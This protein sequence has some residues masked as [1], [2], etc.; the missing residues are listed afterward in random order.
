MSLNHIKM[1]AVKVKWPQSDD[2][3]AESEDTTTW[4]GAC[5]EKYDLDF[6]PWRYQ[7]HATVD[8]HIW[9]LFLARGIAMM[10]TT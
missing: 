8:S 3:V 2:D 1:R 10:K 5:S 4:Y 6:T 7:S 9:F